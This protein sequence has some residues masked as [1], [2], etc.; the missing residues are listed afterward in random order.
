[1]LRSDFHWRRCWRSCRCWV[2]IIFC[3]EGNWGVSSALM[4]MLFKEWMSL[5]LAVLRKR[6]SSMRLSRIQWA[7]RSQPIQDKIGGFS[8]VSLSSS[9]SCAQGF[10]TCA[11]PLVGAPSLPWITAG[12]EIYLLRQNKNGGVSIYCLNTGA[13]VRRRCLSHK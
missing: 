5:A 9:Q 10:A 6:H 4:S 11:P 2:P 13:R 7:V 12:W 1:V 8:K 3:S